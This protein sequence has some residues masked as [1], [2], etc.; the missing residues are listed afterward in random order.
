MQVTLS[1]GSS[2]FIRTEILFELSLNVG[3]QLDEAYVELIREEDA[4]LQCWDKALDL[5][6]RREHASAELRLKLQQRRF[7]SHHI[8]KALN[9]LLV[10][11]FLDDHR[12]AERWI[13]VRIRRKA[14]G[15]SKLKAALLGKGVGREIAEEVLNET[16][17]KEQEQKALERALEKIARSEGDTKKIVAKM[18]RKGFSKAL[19][20]RAIDDFLDSNKGL[21]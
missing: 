15:R 8:D 21:H 17:S 5:L 11:G 20:F 1:D 6:S 4:Y 14:E 10:L 13:E 2:F 7:P 9:R 3:Q 12:F 18:M 16:F 19:I